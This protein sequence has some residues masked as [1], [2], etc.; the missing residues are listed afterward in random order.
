MSYTLTNN[1][2]HAGTKGGTDW[3]RWTA[4]I[5][6]TDDSKLDDIKYVEYQLHSSFKNPIK[7]IRKPNDG[8][9]LSMKGWGTFLLRARLVFNDSSKVPITLEHELQFS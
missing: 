3:W 7:R 2:E 8:F 4:F 6:A 9:A 1:S 5:E